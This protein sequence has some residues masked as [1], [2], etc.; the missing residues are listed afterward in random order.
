[1]KT[2]RIITTLLSTFLLSVSMTSHAMLVEDPTE[3]AKT[4]E[5]LHQL[6]TQYEILQRQYNMVTNQFNQLKQQYGAITGNYGWGNLHNSLS[7]LEH[8]REFTA[9]KWHDALNGLSGGNPA[10]FNQLLS[11]YK[12]SHRTLDTNV[13]AKGADKQ[14]AVMYQNEVKTNQA[15]A[16]TATYE[17]NDIN[18]HLKMLYDLG[19]QIENS[20]KNNDLKSAIDLNSRINLEI[21]YINAEE[22]RMTT[23]L[24]QQLAQLQASRI[25][26]ESEASQFNQAGE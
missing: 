5:V 2:K 21:G 11:L 13:Y 19:Q 15:S 16:T 24:N 10:R 17:F 9:S 7:D 18:K 23:I 3:W 12:Q 26:L 20:K 14:L 1:M 8:E 25:A 4:L 22:V 6:S